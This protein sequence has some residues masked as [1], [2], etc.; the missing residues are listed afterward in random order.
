MA[1]IQDI[2]QTI[3][4]SVDKLSGFAGSQ[5]Q[6][7]FNELLGYVKKL[8]TRGDNILNNKENLRLVNLIKVKLERLIVDPKYKEQLKQFAASY[9]DIADLQ[10]EY[11][12]Q[13][14]AAY[15][16]NTGLNALKKSSV[17]TTITNLTETGI[18]A[19]VISGLKKIL[20]TNITAG[21]SYAQLTEQLR[22]YMLTNETGE[23]ALQRY[24][25]T[26][27]NTAINQYSA[28]YNKAVADDLGLEWFMYTGSL[29]E[30]SREFCRKAVEKKYIH[31]SEFETLLHGDFGSLGKVHV[32][33][34]TSLPDGMMEGT[35]KE[36]FPRRRGG[37]N[38]GHQLIAV[39][40]SAVP[41][42][43]RDVIYNSDAYKSWALNN[44]KQLKQPSGQGISQSKQTNFVKDDMS[45]V[46]AS[47]SG[48]VP[49]TTQQLLNLSG[50]VPS[51]RVNKTFLTASFNETYNFIDVENRSDHYFVV[52]KIYPEKKE[53][54]NSL[55]E[56]YDKGQGTGTN[57]FLNQVMEAIRSGFQ[58]F[59]VSAA[60]SVSYNGYYTWA[61]MGYSIKQSQQ[62]QFLELMRTNNRSEKLLREL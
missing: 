30:T 56:V 3:K 31:I 60:K 23:G 24:V 36:N 38:C 25:T 8:E 55:M 35:N 52:R 9:K 57:I 14:N 51:T 21:G 45:N 6:R 11:F 59:S 50:G 46:E 42:N 2:L 53:I 41:Q 15:K 27:A 16:P 12:S 43:V 33:K 13:F 44:G 54:Y 28:E 20:T 37:W 22:N 32:N 17:E 61:R 5:Q 49:Y 26:Y 40:D 62:N 1:S 29:L 34:K 47:I 18:D 19:G 10:N 4:S 7:I 39:A 48:K 58:K